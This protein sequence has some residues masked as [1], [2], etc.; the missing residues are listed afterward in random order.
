MQHVLNLSEVRRLVGRH[1][2]A[3]H[4]ERDDAFDREHG[5]VVEVDPLLIVPAV[6]MQSGALF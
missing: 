6:H 1:A 3:S 5:L 4:L 2:E